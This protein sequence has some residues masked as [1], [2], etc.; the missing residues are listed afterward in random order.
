MKKEKTLLDKAMDIP[1]R[2]TIYS[3]DHEQ[4]LDLSIAYAQNK[5]SCSQ[6]SKALGIPTHSGNIT[7]RMS[8]CIVT[9]I[10]QGKVK[11]SKA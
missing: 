6:A 11:I 2:Q 8:S 1:R 4:L 3:I 5:I 9:A 7:T 10:R